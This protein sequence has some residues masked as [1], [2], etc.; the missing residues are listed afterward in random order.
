MQAAGHQARVG[1]NSESSGSGSG[2]NGS[3]SGVGAAAAAAAV[4][5][6]GA[7]ARWQR[8]QKRFKLRERQRSSGTVV[9]STGVSILLVYPNGNHAS[10]LI[11]AIKAARD[12][13]LAF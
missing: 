8:E 1:R 10:E 2:R 4:R 7:A 3:S 6:R 11:A 12:V 9:A 13:R 5:A